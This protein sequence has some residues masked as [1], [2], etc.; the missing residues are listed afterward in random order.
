MEIINKYGKNPDSLLLIERPKDNTK[1][2]NFRFHIDSSLNR[3][4]WVPRR[5]DKQGR[6]E[7]AVIDLEH[8]ISN[9]EKNCWNGGYFEFNEPKPNSSRRNPSTP[10]QNT[11][12][13]E[14][15][16]SI[17]ESEVAKSSPNF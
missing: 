10:E 6:D 14:L 16:S 17:E 7:V 8:L 2:G 13:L 1:R 5:P 15:V 11:I 3:K 12:E 9:N 4:V